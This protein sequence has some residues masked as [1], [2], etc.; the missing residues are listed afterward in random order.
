MK[1]IC[2]VVKSRQQQQGVVLIIAMILMVVMAVSA[3]AAVRLSGI[4]DLINSNTRSRVMALQAAEAAVNYCRNK[5]LNS[6]SL[7]ILT[8]TD[9]DD[10][11]N[12]WRD[13]SNW[14]GSTVNKIDA[15]DVLGQVTSYT[16]GTTNPECIVEDITEFVENNT[17]AE[18]SD[19]QRVVAYRIT[20]RG[21]SPNYKASNGYQ[22]AGAQAWV[23]IVVGRTLG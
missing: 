22:Q 9:A 6:T 2:K 1:M 3:L 20:A 10:E 11:G 4:D 19:V 7:A 18:T 12:K 8:A 21:F 17:T 13:M 5:A 15:K 23:Q 14:A 16:N